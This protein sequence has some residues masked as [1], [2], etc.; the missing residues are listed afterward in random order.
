MLAT[1]IVPSEVVYFRSCSPVE[2]IGL[3][4]LGGR[5]DGCG[6]SLLFGRASEPVRGVC[7]NLEG[8]GSEV[9]G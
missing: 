6:L 7:K 3:G 1:K 8:R 5:I 4:V 2:G 9:V